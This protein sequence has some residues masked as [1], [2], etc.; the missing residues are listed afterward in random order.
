MLV[1]KLPSFK[2]FYSDP[3][4]YVY[5]FL[6]SMHNLIEIYFIFCLKTSVGN[7]LINIYKNPFNNVFLNNIPHIS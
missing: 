4:I 1:E 2:A 6:I 7:K 3:K 5:I